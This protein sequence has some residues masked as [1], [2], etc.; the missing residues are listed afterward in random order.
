ME[1][2]N[3]LTWCTH[4]HHPCQNCQLLSS[5]SRGGNI[6]KEMKLYPVLAFTFLS[7]FLLSE[8]SVI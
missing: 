4:T 5:T 6:Y 8:V 3:L 2:Q 7:L 1:H